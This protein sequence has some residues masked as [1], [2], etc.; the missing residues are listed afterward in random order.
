MT[1]R[2]H[3]R[4]AHITALRSAETGLAADHSGEYRPDLA[5]PQLTAFTLFLSSRFDQNLLDVRMTSPTRCVQEGL[6]IR[7]SGVNVR[8]RAYQNPC[9]FDM[10]SPYSFVQKW[11]VGGVSGVNVRI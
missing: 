2:H 3:P 9:N 6:A 5:A 10:V 8:A 4:H 11:I 7:P 1:L